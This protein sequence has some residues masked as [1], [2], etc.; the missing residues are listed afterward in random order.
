MKKISLQYKI[1]ALLL[2]L[3]F[4]FQSMETINNHTYNIG[5][6][7]YHYQCGCFGCYPTHL[8]MTCTSK[9]YH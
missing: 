4:T 1:I 2:V 7:N 3:T 5:V 6:D 9:K 8:S